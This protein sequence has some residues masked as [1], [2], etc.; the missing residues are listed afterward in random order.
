ME[1]R[2]GSRGL[3]LGGRREVKGRGWNSR[4]WEVILGRGESG[5]REKFMDMDSMSNGLIGR[6]KTKR[7]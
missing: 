3:R 2:G 7:F 6:P 4:S 1:K 5:K